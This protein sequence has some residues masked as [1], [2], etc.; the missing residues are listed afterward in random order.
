MLDKDKDGY[1]DLSEF[2]NGLY[3]LLTEEFERLSEFIFNIY[4]F[5]SDGYINPEDIRV[6]LAYLPLKS[7]NKALIMENTGFGYIY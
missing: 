2:I 6:I 1:L 7:T 4:D 5:D 3:T